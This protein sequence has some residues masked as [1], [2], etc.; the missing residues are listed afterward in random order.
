MYSIPISALRRQG[1]TDGRP[2]LGVAALSLDVGVCLR[3]RRARLGG[4]RW[5]LFLGRSHVLGAFV[6]QPLRLPI[7]S[8]WLTV[9]LLTLFMQLLRTRLY[10]RLV[11]L[12]ST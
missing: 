9:S 4:P 7:V 5:R 10:S 6:G 3:I 1:G 11:L 12:P 2:V 8:S